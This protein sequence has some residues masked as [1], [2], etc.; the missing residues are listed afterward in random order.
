[1]TPPVEKF[2]LDLKDPFEEQLSRI[3]ALHRERN[4]QYMTSPLDIL[5]VE[6]WLNQIA[7]KGMRACQAIHTV[8]IVDELKDN[9]VYSVMTLEQIEKQDWSRPSVSD[10]SDDVE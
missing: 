8:K 5:P 2:E 10:A 9:I 6:M 7:I 4:S 3:A 1:M